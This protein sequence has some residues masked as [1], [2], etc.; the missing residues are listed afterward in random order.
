MK[1]GNA[2]EILRQARVR[3]F[4]V[5]DKDWNGIKAG[6]YVVNV[7]FPASVFEGK[8]IIE[9]EKEIHSYSGE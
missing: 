5:Y 1:T 9:I 6:E 3:G 8:S 4:E 7:D 2:I